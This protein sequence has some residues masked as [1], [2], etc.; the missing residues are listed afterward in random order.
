MAENYGLKISKAGTDV[1]TGADVDMEVSSKF[2]MFKMKTRGTT[3]LRMYKTQLTANI[4]ASQ[5]TIPLK[6]VTG[7]PT[8]SALTTRPWIW[9]MSSLHGYVWEAVSFASVTAGSVFGG[10]RGYK[11]GYSGQTAASADTVVVG[12]NEVSISHGL[13]YPPVHFVA[14]DNSSYGNVLIPNY[15]DELG[16]FIVRAKVNSDNLIVLFDNEDFNSGAFTPSGAYTQYDFIYHI[17]LDS[18]TT[19]YY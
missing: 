10:A 18:L 6:S 2:P 3:Y 8:P 19:P 12:Y 9:I 5:T 15:L 7:F 16:V 11:S 14:K 13:T 4:N 1:T 17:M